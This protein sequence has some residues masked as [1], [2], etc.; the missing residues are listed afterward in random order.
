VAA[1]VAILVGLALEV[2]ANAM[3]FGP[4]LARLL[5]STSTGRTRR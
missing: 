2:P 3:T 1:P 4:M 5:L